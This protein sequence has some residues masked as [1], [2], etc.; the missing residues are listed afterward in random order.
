[1]IKRLQD[2]GRTVAMVG[3]GVNDDAALAQADL[4]LAM[5]FSSVFVAREACACAASPRVP[6]TPGPSASDG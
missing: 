3:D 2:E 5:A 1:V 6:G 4:G